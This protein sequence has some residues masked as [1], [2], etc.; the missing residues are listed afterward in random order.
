[1]GG[2]AQAVRDQA[3]RHPR[4]TLGILQRLGDRLGV[5][6]AVGSGSV[7]LYVSWLAP[8]PTNSA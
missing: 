2:D 8:K 7:T 1:M 6:V 3:D 4:A 5:A